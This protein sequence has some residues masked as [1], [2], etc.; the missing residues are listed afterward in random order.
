[1]CWEALNNIAA[2]HLPIVIVVNDNG[3]SYDRT[4]G[5]L[6]EHL[7]TLRMTQGYEK[8]LETVRTRSSAR[9]SSGRRST[10]PCTASSA[11]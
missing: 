3:R 6:A 8:T 10:P 11:G 2:G 5:G 7:A 1:M 9:P 4:V